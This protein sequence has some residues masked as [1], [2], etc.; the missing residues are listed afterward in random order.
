MFLWK[1]RNIP[2]KEDD[3]ASLRSSRGLADVCLL[4]LDGTVGGQ[5]EWVIMPRVPQG[6]GVKCK[7]AGC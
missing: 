3:P 7:S 6:H 1:N 4:Y 5:P 2:I